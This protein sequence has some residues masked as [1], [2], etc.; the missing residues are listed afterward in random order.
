MG[1]LSRLTGAVTPTKKASDD[2]LLLHGMLL[3][4]GADGTIEQG[5]IETV[6]A[7]FAT[8]PE[9]QG[10]DF[11]DLYNEAVKVL[12][13]FPSVKDS[14]KALGEITSPVIRKKLYVLAA[15]IA[16]SSGDVDEQEDELLETMQR[17]LDVDDALATKVLEVLA[18]KYAK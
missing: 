6:E 1:L 10:K 5:E 8:L 18:V 13:K 2:V 4:A 11:G 7:Y 14:V 16:M 3:M 12:R 15:D 17:L 9:F